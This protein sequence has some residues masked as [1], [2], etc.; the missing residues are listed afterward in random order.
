MTNMFS[1]YTKCFQLSK[2][3]RFSLIPQGKTL[4]NI[5]KNSIITEDDVRAEKYKKVKPVLDKYHRYFIENAM[6]G[7]QGDWTELFRL[8]AEN[9]KLRR[10]GGLSGEEGESG[11][12]KKTPLE[13]EQEKL[14]K[15][16]SKYL[17]KHPDY[18]TL[19][20]KA[21]IEKAVKSQ[22]MPEDIT[23]EDVEN[24]K[25]FNKF[26]TYFSGYKENRENIYGE[27]KSVSVAYRTVNDNFTKFAADCR[28]F[29]TLFEEDV[30][31]YENELKPILKG[32][33]LREIFTP[34]F[35]N[36]ILNQKGIDFFNSVLGGM[37]ESETVKIK[38]LNELCNLDFQQR[39]ERKIKFIPLF[40]QILGGSEKLSFI[41]SQF[42]SDDQLIK[43]VREY[44]EYLQNETEKSSQ[45]FIGALKAQNFDS[46]NVF[47]DKKQLSVFS[48]I[49]FDGDWSKLGYTLKES[50]IKD[51]SIYTLA[52]VVKVCEGK[53]PVEAFCA[54]LKE[55]LCELPK[56]KE[57]ADQSLSGNRIASYDP[58]KG[59]LDKVQEC[60]KLLKIFAVGEDA[61][62]D[63]EFYFFFDALYTPFRENIAIYNRVRNYATRKLDETV[64][65]SLRF[66]YGNFLGGWVDSKTE[67]SDNGTQ[68]GG[69]LFRK[70]RNDG[71]YDYFLGI[72]RATKI[73]RPVSDGA[74]SEY[75]RLYYYQLKSQSVF[76]S[77][78]AG[79]Q[80]YSEDKSEIIEIIK[81][82]AEKNELDIFEKIDFS[83][84]KLTPAKLISI[85][86]NNDSEKVFLSDSRFSE[87]NQE[88]IINIKNSLYKVADKIPQINLVNQSEFKFCSDMID[89]VDELSKIKSK[90]FVKISAKEMEEVLNRETNPLYLFKISNKDL[91]H[92]AKYSKNGKKNL[93]TMYFEELM[94]GN[95]T[96]DLGSGMVFFRPKAIEN[97]FMHRAG[98][99]VVN[100]HGKDGNVLSEEVH[101]ELV[102]YFN[103]RISSLSKQSESE[104]ENAVV[105]KTSNN[106]IKDKRYSENKF[107]FHLST[108]INPELPKNAKNFNASVL[109]KIAG[110]KDVN[111]IGIDRGERNLIYVSCINQK[112]EILEQRSF[113]VVGSTDY[114]KKLDDLE[115]QRDAARK[116]W[117]SIDRIKDMKEGYLSGVIH[118]ITNMMLR[119]NAIVVMEDLNFDFKRGRF[120]IEKQVYQKFEKMLIDKLNY[121]ADKSKE[122]YAEGGVC[123]GYQLAD[124]FESFQRLGRQSGFIFYV[125][126]A[127][128]SKIDPKTGFVNLFTSE[129]LNYSSV[130]KTKSFF[131]AFESISYNSEKKYFAFTFDYEK[132]NLRRHDSTKRWTVCTYGD[133][134]CYTKKDGYHSTEKVNVT[135]RMYNLLKENGIA[136]ESGEL[137][138]KITALNA[139]EFF[140]TFLWLFKVVLQLRY[141]SP[142]EDFILSPVE[143]DGRFFDSRTAADN[144]PSNGDAN[145]AYHI[146]LQGLRLI[147]QRIEFKGNKVL[148]KKDEPGKQLYNWLKFAQDKPYLN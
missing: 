95:D 136:P 112:G 32:Y 35:Y 25:C 51:K 84:E 103:G 77:L 9:Q 60:E 4:E 104:K 110:N 43:A 49:I 56:L 146:A 138:E 12:K 102:E 71:D 53:T 126:A 40:G 30:D 36:N 124:K 7:F 137:I 50:G 97:P 58:L 119:Y 139:K 15:S 115:K 18:K 5:E 2:T 52:E 94:N 135:E 130:D 134:I 140:S 1:D 122:P 108:F 123:C 66:G 64:K 118:E 100:R 125:P 132:F 121:L 20:P 98:E 78:Y 113:N 26:S 14:R 3:L 47:I 106:I 141:E 19:D 16:I 27:E 6:G 29:A 54:V 34:E 79:K 73:L 86:K 87:K 76:G 33:S 133:R 23:A 21:I 142:E 81:L 48:Q 83:D 107:L 61:E 75:E 109:E 148:I 74:Y 143:S 91:N 13:T 144:E 147:T 89:V 70:K 116:N 69:Y 22:D 72:S 46:E 129:Q 28:L 8:L 120:H 31:R 67:K 93:H 88:I 45:N 10:E 39:G 17:T 80:P 59:Y 128:T 96:F 82:V 42:E 92:S 55:K 44:G 145:G 65:I 62:G 90:P 105:H 38:G 11:E 99:Y 127:N 68:Y 24:L 111:I 131:K 41:P 57:E 63:G 117:K 85:I 101:K 37:T 114:H